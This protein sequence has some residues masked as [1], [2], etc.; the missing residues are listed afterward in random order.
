MHPPA[1]F[2]LFFIK[3]RFEIASSKDEAALAGVSFSL[4]GNEKEK[5]GITVLTPELMRSQSSV[6]VSPAGDRKTGPMPDSSGQRSCPNAFILKYVK[7]LIGFEPI[8]DCFE[9]S[10]YTNSAKDAI[11]KFLFLFSTSGHA[12]GP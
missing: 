2:D 10:C 6:G 8:P 9:G 4:G 1:A 11:S 3:N 5:S 12:R 7:H